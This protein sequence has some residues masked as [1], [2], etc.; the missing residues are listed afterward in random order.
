M[1]YL[2]EQGYSSATSTGQ[3]I[4][5]PIRQTGDGSL[6]VPTV[7]GSSV[8]ILDRAQVVIVDAAAV[9]LL[10]STATYTF[11]NGEPSTSYA[12]GDGWTVIWTLVIAGEVYTFRH[13]A[14]LC[15]YVPRNVIT[16]ADLYGGDGIP[17]LR[18]AVPQS[19]GERGDGTG[20]APQIDAAYYEL[21]RRM[22]ADGRPIWRSREPTGYRDWLL[23]LAIL[24][25]TESIPAP[26]GSMWALERRNAFSRWKRA[27]AGMRLQYDTDDAAIRRPGEGPIYMTPVGRPSW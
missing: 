6:V 11:A 20:W 4:E 26:D 9:T 14:I 18:H 7:L 22:L 23:G 24:R 27:E 10:G 19:Q 12:L 25:A 13:A 16:A 1:P 8:S 3:T 15:E 5:A 2:L 21:I 17:E